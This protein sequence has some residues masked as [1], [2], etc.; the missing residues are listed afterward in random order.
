MS[1]LEPARESEVANHF[2]ALV[3]SRID[4]SLAPNVCKSLHQLALKQ[5]DRHRESAAQVRRAGIY[6][7]AAAQ[8]FLHAGLRVWTSCKDQRL[9]EGDNIW[10]RLLGGEDGSKPTWLEN[11]GFGVG[12]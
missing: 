4:P 9:Y 7:L 11:D 10:K 5:F 8:S 1:W 3:L 2:G 12:R 6:I